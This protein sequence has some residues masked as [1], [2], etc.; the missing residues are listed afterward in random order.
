MDPILNFFEIDVL[1]F[2]NILKNLL[3][4]VVNYIH[5]EQIFNLKYLI[6]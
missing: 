4:D 1:K 3:E 2:Q 5:Q 6:F